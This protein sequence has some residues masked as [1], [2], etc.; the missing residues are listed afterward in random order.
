MKKVFITL[1]CAA[2]LFAVTSCGNDNK[3]KTDL[4]EQEQAAVDST[5]NSDQAQ[6]DSLENAIKS[7]IGEDSVDSHEGHEGHSH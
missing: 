5:I 3:P 2:A 6:M 7:Q 4:N 1:T